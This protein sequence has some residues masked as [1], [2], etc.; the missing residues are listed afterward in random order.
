MPSGFCILAEVADF[1]KQGD[2]KNLSAAETSL[3]RRHKQQNSNAWLGFLSSKQ[4]DINFRMSVPEQNRWKCA[5][6]HEIKR[7]SIW[8]E[9]GIMSRHFDTWSEHMMDCYKTAE[10][11]AKAGSWECLPWPTRKVS[12]THNSLH[13]IYFFKT[14][15][16]AKWEEIWHHH[17]SR[18]S[19]GHA[20]S[21]QSMTSVKASNNG[22]IAVKVTGELLQ[23]GMH[24]I[25]C[26]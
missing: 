3:P 18:I 20:C 5:A 15:V 26:K 1:K 14:E 4:S 2:C 16:G 24:W 7:V 23:A 8:N 21:V 9:V 22:T 6:Q 11:Q 10:S 12:D 13:H 17:N 19:K 25:K